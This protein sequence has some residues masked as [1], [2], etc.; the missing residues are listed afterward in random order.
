MA[1]QQQQ[2]QDFRQGLQ[3]LANR[4]QEASVAPVALVHQLQLQ[5]VLEHNPWAAEAALEAHLQHQAQV[6]HQRQVG[7][8]PQL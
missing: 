3:H 2:Q 5:A 7:G 8:Q 6:L 1:V 4:Q